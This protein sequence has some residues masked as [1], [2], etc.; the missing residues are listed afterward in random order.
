MWHI[1]WP[2]L[3]CTHCSVMHPG[4]S[5]CSWHQN[6]DK[7]LELFKNNVFICNIEL[8]KNVRL[9]TEMSA[10]SFR[11]WSFSSGFIRLNEAQRS[12]NGKHL[13]CGLEVILSTFPSQGCRVEGNG[14]SCACFPWGDH[15]GFGMSL[16]L[17]CQEVVLAQLSLSLNA[18]AEPGLGTRV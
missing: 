3:P 8:L 12:K 14:R 2:G 6:L 7:W 5:T 16:Y 18:V 4:H 1:P 11:R 15:P 17:L 13:L 10:I 9:P